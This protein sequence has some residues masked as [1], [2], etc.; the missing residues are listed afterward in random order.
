VRPNLTL[1]LGLRWDFYGLPYERDGLQG[2]LDQVANL[3]MW[4]NIN[5]LTVKKSSD[6]YKNDWNN[7]GPRLGFAWA[8]GDGKTSIRG[9]YGLYYDR[10]IGATV[11]AAD[12]ATPGF[13]QAGTLFPNQAAGSDVRIT[14]DGGP[15]TAPVPATVVLQRPN[16][17]LNTV[18]LFNPNLVNGYVHHFNLSIQREIFRNTILEVAYVGTKGVKLFMQRDINQTK[19][20]GDFLNAFNELAAYRNGGANNGPPVSPTNTLVRIFGST[21]AAISTI[22]GS[23]LDQGLVGTAANTVDRNNYTKYV[24]AGVSDFYLR[25]YPQFNN[26]QYGSNDGRSY[27]DSLQFGIRRQ[28]GALKMS[29][30]YTFSKSLDNTSVDANGFTSPIDN[31]NVDL[32]KARGD[33]DRPHSANWATTYTLPI[34][35]NH[36]IGRNFPGWANN[37]FSGWDLG[38]LGVWQSGGVFTVSSG[39]AT[40]NNDANS[41]ANYTGDRNIGEVSRQPIAG[42]TGVWFFTAQQIAAFSFPAAGSIGTAGRNTFRGPR[43]FNIDMSVVKKFKV[44]ETHSVSF[45][46]EAY[47][48]LNNPNFANPS[49]TYS[50]AATSTFGKISG[51]TNAARIWQMALRYD[52]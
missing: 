33:Y 41:W 51:T 43:Y 2:T 18:T 28:M 11:S 17:R 10:V 37:I 30:N 19:V 14:A 40:Y 36:A 50:N 20:K 48:L 27:Y 1:N 22:G 9:G 47:N 38:M 23:T 12:G 45:R 44:T 31:Y 7:F 4:N 6:W 49:A 42:Q 15:P 3:T 21:S 25:N 34:G 8:P 5:N 16:D 39:R 29:F 13:S 24:A 35:N 26:V 52:F 32:N 46:A